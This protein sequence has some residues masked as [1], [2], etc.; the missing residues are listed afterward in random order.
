MEENTGTVA[1]FDIDDLNSVDEGKMMVLAGDRP[2]GWEWTFAGPGHPMGIAQTN[3]I[4]RE[5][6]SRQRSQEQARVNNKKYKAEE[7]S[8]DDLL[9]EN[10]N[11]ILE[12][13][14]GWSDVNMNGKPFPFSRENARS[15]L[16]DKRKATI[17]N[18]CI[19]FI[20]N[21]NSF[22]KRSAKP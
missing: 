12:R 19:E 21:D 3:R 22:T 15:I 9:E 16:K 2:T 5:E 17:L 11:F 13:L 7:K 14:L 8:P 18:Q 4:A 10:V 6:L 20:L 1:T